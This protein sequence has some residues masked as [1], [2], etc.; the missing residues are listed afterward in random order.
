MWFA[1]RE[2]ILTFDEQM[3]ICRRLRTSEAAMRVESWRFWMSASLDDS[4]AA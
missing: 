4:A 2:R 3:A 1:E